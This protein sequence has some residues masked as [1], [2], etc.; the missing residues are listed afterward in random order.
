VI[1]DKSD[2]LKV[3]FGVQVNGRI[4]DSAFTIA[5]DHTYDNLLLS[6]KEAT[7]AGIAVCSP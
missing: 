6:V 5:F 2:V 3:D 1:L 7:N 4:V